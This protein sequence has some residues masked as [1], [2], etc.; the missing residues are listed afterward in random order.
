MCYAR[1]EVQVAGV[2]VATWFGGA[3]TGQTPCPLME[4]HLRVECRLVVICLGV[5][6]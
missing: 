1:I 5:R 2:G 3:D 6:P 4:V